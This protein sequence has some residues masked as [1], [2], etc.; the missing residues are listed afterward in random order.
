MRV[1]GI[2]FRAT[3]DLASLQ[4]A[5]RLALESAGPAKIDTLV[6]EAAKSREKVFQEFAGLMGIPGLGVTQADLQQMI[7]PTQSQRIQD[8]FGTGSLAE[9]AALVAAGPNARLV[10]PRV[11]SGDANA[12]AAIAQNVE[13]NQT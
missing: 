1:L 2:G 11:V 4:D 5:M 8:K 6:T 7:T 12:T 13:E 10:A 3:A 9:A